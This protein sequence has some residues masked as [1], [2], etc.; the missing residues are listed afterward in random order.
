LPAPPQQITYLV[1]MAKKQ[2]NKVAESIRAEDYVLIIEDY[3]AY[4]LRHDRITVYA[5][6]VTTKQ[7]Q[8]AKREAQRTQA[9]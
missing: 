2:W 4:E 5:L 6:S 1:L 9:E 3:P 7:H 8:Q